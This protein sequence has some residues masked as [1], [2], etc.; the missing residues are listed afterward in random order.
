[1]RTAYTGWINCALVVILGIILALFALACGRTALPHG[2]WVGVLTVWLTSGIVVLAACL[3]GASSLLRSDRRWVLAIG[4]LFVATRLLWITAVSVEQVSDFRT[5]HRLA[6]RL[7]STAPLGTVSTDVLLRPWGYP[8]LLAAVYS[9]TGPDESVGQVVNVALG[10]TT[11]VL[12]FLLTRAVFGQLAARVATALMLVWPAQLFFTGVLASEHL[13]VVFATAAALCLVGGTA[14]TRSAWWTFA[15]AGGLSLAGYIVRPPL[16]V[17]LPVA[18]LAVSFCRLT[19][20]RRVA[21]AGTVLLTF[22]A[23]DWAYRATMEKLYGV[24]PSRSGAFNLLMGTNA[25]S[26]GH[27]NEADCQWFADHESFE[28]ANRRAWREAARRIAAD[29]LGF[30]TLMARKPVRTWSGEG[31]A[32]AWTLDLGR[33]TE[34]P[35][36]RAAYAYCRSFHLLILILATIG[37]FLSLR[38]YAGPAASILAAIILAAVFLHAVTEAQERYHFV[39]SPFLL[40]FAGACGAGLWGLRKRAVDSSFQAGTGAGEASA[41]ATLPATHDA[42]SARDACLTS[43]DG[44]LKSK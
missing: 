28:E 37:C 12:L 13:G 6:I 9:A 1:M 3:A 5:Y 19:P 27:W 26:V 7:G 39:F 44:D 18:L 43:G 15:A 41:R 31:F 35:R 20:R 2:Q 4:S 40:A 34:R 14:D 32:V 23:G 22:V 36:L 24:S 16:I 17:L 38:K 10:L 29:P 42:R 25:D 21:A 30:L 8:L 11:L 33:T